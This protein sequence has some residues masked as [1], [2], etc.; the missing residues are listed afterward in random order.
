MLFP[1]RNYVYRRG[2]SMVGVQSNYDK[3]LKTKLEWRWLLEDFYDG[4]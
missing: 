2:F 3:L 1:S 4:P